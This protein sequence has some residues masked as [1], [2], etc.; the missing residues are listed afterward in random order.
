[1]MVDNFEN[2]ENLN[3][4]QPPT[5]KVMITVPQGDSLLQGWSEIH[6]RKMGGRF[7]KKSM[8]WKLPEEFLSSSPPTVIVLEETPVVVV[9]MEQGEPTVPP[10]PTAPTVSTTTTQTVATVVIVVDKETQTDIPPI[11]DIP[12]IPISDISPHIQPPPILL[13]EQFQ[14]RKCGIEEEILQRMTKYLA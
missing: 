4:Q 5:T 6:L 1:M 9:S 13:E 11:S 14:Y 2:S 8:S 3:V 12:P 10:P 7:Y